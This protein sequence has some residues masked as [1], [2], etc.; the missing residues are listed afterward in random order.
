MSPVPTTYLFKGVSAVGVHK[1]CRSILLEVVELK[2]L[3]FLLI[4]K[5]G[6]AGNNSR[7]NW[8]MGMQW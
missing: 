4:S 5:V 1:G 8:C 6:P 7:C 2:R 3:D